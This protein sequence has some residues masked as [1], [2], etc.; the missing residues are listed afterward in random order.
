M[1]SG[2]VGNRHEGRL[3]ENLG[4]RKCGGAATALA[5]SSYREDEWRSYRTRGLP[6]GFR[7]NY[8]TISVKA[9][10]GFL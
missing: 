10:S 6:C 4:F 7:V 1:A 8:R 5:G 2:L 3:A 9:N